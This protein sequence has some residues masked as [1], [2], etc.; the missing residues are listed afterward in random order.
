M[1][2]NRVYV[3]PVKVLGNEIYVSSFEEVTGRQG[4]KPYY[5]YEI[6]SPKERSA[7][8]IIDRVRTAPRINRLSKVKA[9]TG[10]SIE[11]R[12]FTCGGKEYHERVFVA[13]S[14]EVE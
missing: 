2:I 8:L 12:D 5:I 3:D 4:D 7:F 6:D 1:A 14:F 11:S 13:D 10:F 9:F